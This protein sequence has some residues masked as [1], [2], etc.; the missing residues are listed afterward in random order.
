[1]N[2]NDIDNDGTPDTVELEKANI[3]REKLVQDAQLEREK[4]NLKREEIQS[5][6]RIAKSKPTKTK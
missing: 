1:M 2:D 4:M 5:K 6:E 3:A